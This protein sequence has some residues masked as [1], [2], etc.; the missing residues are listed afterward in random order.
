MPLELRRNEDGTLDEL[1][2]FDASV[3][4]LEQMDVDH[5]SL[6]VAAGGRTVYVNLFTRRVDVIR[7]RSVIH[8][9]VEE[10]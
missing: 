4:T 9:R 3:V 10:E 5:W 1:V 6:M 2:V 7:R 8:V